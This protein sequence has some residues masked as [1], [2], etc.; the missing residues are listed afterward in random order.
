MGV[1]TK[2][3]IQNKIM[4]CERMCEMYMYMAYFSARQNI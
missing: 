2:I 4:C 3:T 1:N